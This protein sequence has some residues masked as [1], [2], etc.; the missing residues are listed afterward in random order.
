MLE[1]VFDPGRHPTATRVGAAA[2][3]GYNAVADPARAFDF[4]LARLLDGIETLVSTRR[5]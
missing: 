2:G 4:G 3:A 1:K 5:P